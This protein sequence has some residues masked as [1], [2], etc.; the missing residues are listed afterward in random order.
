MSRVRVP[1]GDPVLNFRVPDATVANTQCGARQG[2][3]RN[4]DCVNR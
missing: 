2:A 3:T 4:M 1:E